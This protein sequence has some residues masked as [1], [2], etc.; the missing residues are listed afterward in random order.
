VIYTDNQFF[1]TCTKSYSFELRQSV[2]KRTVSVRF[3][4][5]LWVEESMNLEIIYCLLKF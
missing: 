5:V 3:R 4:T 2:R 1:L